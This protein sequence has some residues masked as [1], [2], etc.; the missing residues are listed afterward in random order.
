MKKFLIVFLLIY[1]CSKSDDNYSVGYISFNN[2]TATV[3]YSGTH[4]VGDSQGIYYYS[5]TGAYPLNY[6]WIVGGGNNDNDY[7][8]I[9]FFSANSN[10]TDSTLTETVAI[11]YNYD[12]KYYASAPLS[13]SVIHISSLENNKLTGSFSGL[14]T[15]IDQKDSI[16]ITNGHLVDV[17]FAH[18]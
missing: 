5:N 16:T 2:E 7:C 18:P 12:G 14:L 3:K 17:P 10:L 4:K 9:T 1:G 13:P 8:A 6:Q 11:T 15:T